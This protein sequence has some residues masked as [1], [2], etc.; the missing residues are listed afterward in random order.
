MPLTPVHR[1][2]HA[3]DEPVDTPALLYQGDKSGNPTFVV[4]GVAEV[5]EYDLL[6]RLD[7]ILKG[8]E[9]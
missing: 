1:A 9:I 5:G 2:Q 8:H 6:E 4:G 7:L 3:R